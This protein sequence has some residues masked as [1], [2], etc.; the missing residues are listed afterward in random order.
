M[1][2]IIGKKMTAVIAVLLCISLICLFAG[3]DNKKTDDLDSSK[4]S[5]QISESDTSAED[6]DIAQGSDEK[7]DFESNAVSDT[8][9]VKDSDKT[10]ETGYDSK[11]DEKT[12]TTDD[13]DG[14]NDDTDMHAE[15]PKLEDFSIMDEYIKDYTFEISFDESLDSYERTY[16][17]KGEYD[18]NSDGVPESINALLKPYNEDGS[19]LVVNDI[20]V[21]LILG[22]PGGEMYIIDI[23]KKD[24]YNEIAV[25]DLGPSDDPAFV[26]YRYDGNELKQLFSIDRA[27]LMDGE[28]K[29]ISSFHL[30]TPLS[31]K[32]YSAWGEYKNG[33]YVI[34]NHDISQHIGKTY[35]VDWTGYF[36]PM[37]EMPENYFDY[38]TW[39]YETQKEFKN[40]KIKLLD[41]Y[42]NDY[43]PTLNWFYVETSEG[44]KGLLYFW[45]GD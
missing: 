7:E 17:V 35:E 18:L 19:Y 27:A 15:D 34:T 16:T 44:E 2:S 42:I 4:E 38:V 31:P 14:N 32:F 39:E 13:E 5:V 40:E 41:V 6:N 11:T 43:D 9:I 37:D 24:K 10:S 33:E 45:I 8:E 3:C 21:P 26:F 36:V 25:F 20:Q 12:D 1:I 23:D 30:S 29:F 28:G 22:H